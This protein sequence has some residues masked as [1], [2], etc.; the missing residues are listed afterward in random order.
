[1]S[2]KQINIGTIQYKFYITIKIISDEYVLIYV[3]RTPYTVELYYKSKPTGV[4]YDEVTEDGITSYKVTSS[5]TPDGTSSLVT[6]G[7]SDDNLTIA[8]TK[9]SFYT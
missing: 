2:R 9:T 5:V 6:S 7:S 4:K 3:P 1:M 8:I